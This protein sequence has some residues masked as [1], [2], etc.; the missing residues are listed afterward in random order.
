VSGANGD[1]IFSIGEVLAKICSRSGLNV[2]GSR[3]YQSIIR[4]GHVS[5]SIRAANHEVKAPVDYIDLLLAIRPDCFVVDATLQF[6]WLVILR[7]Q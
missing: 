1:G 6:K 7:L 2:H 3:A 5:Y 4:G